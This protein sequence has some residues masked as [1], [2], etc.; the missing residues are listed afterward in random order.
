MGQLGNEDER[1]T[2]TKPYDISKRR[3]LEAYRHVR[4]NRGA[5]GIDDESIEMFEADL[6][7]N[8]YKLWNRMASGSYF[9]PPVKQVE[10]PKK[11]GGVRVLGVPTVADRIGQQVVKARI[12]G[13]L[14]GLFHPD[15][16]GYRLKKSAADAVAVTRERCW[17]YDWCVEFDIRRAFDELDWELLRKAIRKHVK[18]PWCLLYIERWLTAP[19]VSVD[20][21]IVQ[22]TKGVP[23]GSVIGPVLMNLYMHSAF[24]AW[25]QREHPRNPFARYADDAVAHCRSESEAKALL[26]AIG[27]RLK[28]CKLELH[29]EKSGVVYCKD[30]NRRGNCPRIRFTFLGFTFRPR[31]A[32]G[33][34]GKAWTSFLPAVSAAAIKQMYQR[35]REWKIPRQTSI[36]LH[37]LATRYN[38]TLRGWLNYYGRFYRSALRPIFDHFDRRL[39]HWARRKYRKLAGLRRPQYWLKRMIHRHPRLFIHWLAFG[40][41]TVRTMGAV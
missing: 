11:Q 41:V 37:V 33:R 1:M 38:T 24:D 28:E 27:G 35:I 2:S 21:Q 22:R 18:D 17:K 4:A 23:Q 19:A 14:E 5:A 20:G 29:P 31:R 8:L 40:R 3:V 36:G 9:P 7:R 10:I 39:Q 15:S 16:Y 13:E 30:S 26:A 6:S 25:M 34:D 12:E 32:K